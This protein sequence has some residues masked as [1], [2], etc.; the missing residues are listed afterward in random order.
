LIVRGLRVRCDKGTNLTRYSR[1]AVTFCVMGMAL[2]GEAGMNHKYPDFF[3]MDSREP[4]TFQ[5]IETNTDELQIV[6]FKIKQIVWTDVGKAASTDAE[7][8]AYETGKAKI[9]V[10]D[11]IYSEGHRIHS[12][13][14]LW[15]S[16]YRV[17]NR[18]VY[19]VDLDSQKPTVMTLNDLII[20]MPGD[21]SVFLAMLEKTDQPDIWQAIRL[22]GDVEDAYSNGQS[23]AGF[24]DK[25]RMVANKTA[26]SRTKK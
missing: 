12:G 22:Q 18:K 5:S 25:L 16:G 10:V 19:I 14:E 3:A 21:E 24:R 8:S 1:V 9:Q 15:L 26:Q 6:A 2:F 17:K 20:L 4:I 23:L 13:D 7:E 11:V